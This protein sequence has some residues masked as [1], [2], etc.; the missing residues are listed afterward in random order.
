[1]RGQ[2]N[3]IP[4]ADEGRIGIGVNMPAIANCLSLCLARQ[5]AGPIVRLPVMIAKLPVDLLA[6]SC[7]MLHVSSELVC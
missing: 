5:F 2:Q 4:T 7:L 3:K 1:M 6:K